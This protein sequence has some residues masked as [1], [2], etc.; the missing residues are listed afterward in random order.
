MEPQTSR[1]LSRGDF[2][3]S[4]PHSLVRSPT[5]IHPPLP[6][7]RYHDFSAIGCAAKRGRG[8]AAREGTPRE[9]DAAGALKAGGDLSDDV[10]HTNLRS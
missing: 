9:R 7:A 3:R 5:C 4:L 10:E 6:P 1:R 2:A 8:D